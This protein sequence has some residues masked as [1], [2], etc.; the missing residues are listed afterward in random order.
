M[1]SVVWIEYP[2]GTGFTQ[3]SVTGKNE[4]EIAAQFLGFWKNFVHTFAIQGY[5]IYIATESYGGV[6][7]PYISS[8]MIDQNDTQNFNLAGLLIQDGVIGDVNNAFQGVVPAFDFVQQHRESLPLDD[9]QMAQLQQ[10]DAKCGFSQYLRDSIQFPPPRSSPEYPPGVAV[11]PNGTF[12]LEKGC[13]YASYFYSILLEMQSLNPCFDI[14]NIHTYCPPPFDPIVQ[15]ISGNPYFNLTAVKQ[16][17]HAPLD[18]DWTL[19]ADEP[20]FAGGQDLSVASSVYHLPH[21]IDT[22]KNVIAVS[23]SLDMVLP[24]NGL[25]LVLQNMTWGGLQ[26]FQQAPCEPFYVPVYN[27]GDYALGLPGGGGVQGTTA[28][29]R[30]LTAVFQALSGHMGPKDLPAG[31]LRNLEKLLG[32]VGSVSEVSPFTLPQLSNMTQLLGDLGN[33]TVKIPT[34]GNQCNT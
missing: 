6:Y 30:G 32:R 14:Y 25:L 17:I 26:G 31:A 10:T 1:T 23:G 13:D 27:Q 18:V 12:A 33:G 7:G 28:T 11:S 29:E 16:A 22:T 3:G 15:G 5:K 34:F 21:V 2:I 4:D 24:T 9:N 8:R 20:V 19:C